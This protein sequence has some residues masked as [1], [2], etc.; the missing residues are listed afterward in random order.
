M[1]EH[2]ISR[3][4]ALQAGAAAAIPA[5][6]PAFVLGAP[7]HTS[8]SDK[9]H[10]AGVGVGGKGFSDLRNLERQENIVAICDVDHRYVGKVFKRY[11]KAA[12]YTDYRVMLEKQKDLDAVVI[13]TPDHTHAVIAMAAI[14]AGKHVFCQKPL[15]HNV[16]EARALAT[17]A[18]DA[19]VATQMGIQGHASEGLRLIAEWIRD[20]AV[21]AVRSVEAWCS[22]SYAPHGHTWWSSPLSDRP[23]EEQP[24][25]D[26][27]DWDVW[28]GPAP[29]R[30]YHSCYHPKVW[31]CWWDF[32]SGMMGDRGAHTLDPVVFALKLGHPETIEATCTGGN[33]EVHPAAA[34]VTYRFGARDGMPP[35]TLTWREGSEP[36]RP[37]EL[38][39]GRRMGDRGGGA[40]FEG[41]K[42]KLMCGIYA[43]HPVLMPDEL[44]K[45]YR[46]PAKTLP[47]VGCSIQQDWARA[48]REGRR[49]CADFSFSGPLT[50]I[51][52]LGNV[53]KRFPG[54]QLKWD[55]GKMV[56]AGDGAAT[57]MVGREYRDG[58]SL[59]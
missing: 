57:K 50:E 48:A 34:V 26:H 3:R 8:P 4:T 41:T 28:L 15:T 43:N 56:F 9:L 35:V 1:S 58:W 42:G 44:M 31:R 38:P 33:D 22:L 52:Q 46:R 47:R 17:A 25:P 7:R 13:A 49:A 51:C 10:V 21:G 36:P 32:G 23:K 55:G 27:L 19:G 5:V 14:K 18:A 59:G 39:A 37:K 11:P 54:R 6:V 30:P 53:A 20:G 24:V 29:L 40:I 2:A 16:R 12:R 45:S